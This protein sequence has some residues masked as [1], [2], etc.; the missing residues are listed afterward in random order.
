[1]A[2]DSPYLLEPIQEGADFTLYR[3]RE[4]GNEMP[5]LALAVAAEQPSQQALRRLEHEYSLATELGEAR[6]GQPIALTRHQG[7]TSSFL[8]ISVVSRSIG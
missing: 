7:R 2:E 5:I 1:M 4:R 8:K 3:G 6:A